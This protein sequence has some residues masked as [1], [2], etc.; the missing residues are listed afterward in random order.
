MKKVNKILAALLL[1]ALTTSAYGVSFEIMPTLSKAIAKADGDPLQDDKIF[2]GVRGNVYINDNVAIQAG[3]EAST[4]N[5]MSDNGL[6]DLERVSLNAVYELNNGYKVRP[7]GLIGFG[8]EKVHRNSPSNDDSQ[9]FFNAG[10]GLKFAISDRVDLVTEG[11]WLRKLENG[12]NDLIATIGLGI[13]IGE[14][15][16]GVSQSTAT[17]VVPSVTQTSEVENAISLEKLREINA[18]KASPAPAVVTESVVTTVENVSVEPIIIEE[19]TYVEDTNFIE[20]TG[21][22]YEAISE[23]GYYVQMAAFFDGDGGA[24]PNRLE[25]KNYPYIFHS[26][27]RKGK[28]ATLILVGPYESKAEAVVAMKYL[29]RL[30]RD[31]FIYHLD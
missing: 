14:T 23:S 12:D 10:G 18:Q 31:A 21:A 9:L 24:L 13:K 16:R 11:K 1:P 6:T 27:N 19:A 20:D 29:K 7:F 4:D 15:T 17:T 2:F 28:D 8:G 30:K 3:V 5:K 22:T 25:R 26:V